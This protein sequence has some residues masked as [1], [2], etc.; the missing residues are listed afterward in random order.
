MNLELFRI[1]E[2][3]RNFPAEKKPAWRFGYNAG[4]IHGNAWIIH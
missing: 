1:E 2:D 3:G 4:G